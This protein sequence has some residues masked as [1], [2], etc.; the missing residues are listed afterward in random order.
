ME[1]IKDN[2]ARKTPFEML[3][4]DDLF[5]NSDLSKVYKK[6][7]KYQYMD[8]ATRETIELLQGFGK[9]MVYIKQ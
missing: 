1:D 7:N 5:Y 4:T 6:I 2:T 8:M 3:K 9:L